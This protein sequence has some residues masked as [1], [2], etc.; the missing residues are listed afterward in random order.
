ML[1]I[2]TAGALFVSAIIMAIGFRVGTDVYNWTKLKVVSR[3]ADKL[4][5]EYEKEG[6][7]L[8]LVEAV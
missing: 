3:Q 7:T 6:K 4:L 1:E 5:K 2:K 8:S